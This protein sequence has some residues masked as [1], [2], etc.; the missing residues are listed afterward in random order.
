MIHV[1]DGCDGAFGRGQHVE[2]ARLLF[3]ASPEDRVV[4]L[5]PV[6]QTGADGGSVADL[7]HTMLTSDAPRMRDLSRASLHAWS[8]PAARWALRHAAGDR[9]MATLLEGPVGRSRRVRAWARRMSEL[10]RVDVFDEQDA[11]AWRRCGV[12]EQRVELRRPDAHTL[13]RRRQE[14]AHSAGVPQVRAELRER[15]M[16]DDDEIMVMPIASPWSALDAQRFVFLLGMLRIHGLPVS[17]VLPAAAWRLVGARVFRKQARLGTR[18]C[19]IEGPMTAWLPA[20]DAA[21]VDAMRPR[22]TLVPFRPRGALRVLMATAEACGV[23]VAVAPGSTL[24]VSPERAPS[25]ADELKPL[26]NLVEQRRD[27]FDAARGY[28]AT[29]GPV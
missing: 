1:F 9:V 20:C 19:V 6:E 26:L 16:A 29:V 12:P 8:R 28:V 2:A 7:P 13:E 15:L 11:S 23:P 18:V 24:E 3:E 4:T 25:V 21:F 14:I 27:S 17:A 10:E 22:E 5:A